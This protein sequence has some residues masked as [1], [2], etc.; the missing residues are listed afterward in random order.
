MKKWIIPSNLKQYDVIG[1]F[2][3]FNEI[4]WTQKSASINV[5]DLVFIYSHSGSQHCI[6]LAGGGAKVYE[7]GDRFADH[8]TGGCLRCTCRRD[9][10]GGDHVRQRTCRMHHHVRC[11][12]PASDPGCEKRNEVIFTIP[13]IWY[14]IFIRFMIKTLRCRET[15]V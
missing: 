5:G 1:A 4:D 11:L 8:G 12:Y 2:N 7:A 15:E 3:Q 6:H 9:R 10:T 14:T 13:T